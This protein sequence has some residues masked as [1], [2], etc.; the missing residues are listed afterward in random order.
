MLA[1]RKWKTH[2][3]RS[4]AFPRFPQTW[5]LVL[6]ESNLPNQT[7]QPDCCAKS[8]KTL[9]PNY[10]CQNRLKSTPTETESNKKN[11]SRWT[12]KQTKQEE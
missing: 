9:N 12:N 4:L 10:T 3:I 8:N 7:P 2:Y 1:K 6:A 5:T 11:V